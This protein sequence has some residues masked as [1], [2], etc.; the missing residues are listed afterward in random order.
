MPS[1]NLIDR[2]KVFEPDTG[3]KIAQRAR[4]VQKSP[5][6]WQNYKQK[7]KATLPK[8]TLVGSRKFFKPHPDP[9]NSHK[10]Q[11]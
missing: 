10:G 3:S 2:F 7:D 4:K 1:G 8:E 9:R 5:Q 6:I 11:K